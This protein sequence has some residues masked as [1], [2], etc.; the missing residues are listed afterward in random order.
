MDFYILFK[1]LHVLA[2]VAWVGGGLA[3]TLQASRAMRTGDDA[4]LIHIAGQTDWVA[5]LLFVPG[6]VATLIF[7]AIATTIYGMWGQMW[8]LISLVGLIA[9][10]GI[11]GAVLGRSTRI[12]K[13]EGA[14]ERGLAAAHRFTTFAQFD[15]IQLLTVVGVMVLKPTWAEWWMLFVVAAIVGGAFYFLLYPLMN[16][17]GAVA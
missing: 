4:E 5:K 2:A 16:R 3:M 6:G 8:V 14:T 12:A 10:M 7:G 11:G 15:M 17:R 1:L 9:S 13:E